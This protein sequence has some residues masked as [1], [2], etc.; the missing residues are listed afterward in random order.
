MLFGSKTD[1]LFFLAFRDHFWKI[2]I[3]VWKSFIICVQIQIYILTSEQV[4]V[5]FLP[6][7]IAGIQPTVEM[8]HH[9]CNLKITYLFFIIK[10]GFL[11]FQFSIFIKIRT[12][13]VWK[14]T[15]T[16]ADFGRVL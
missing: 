12:V 16:V 5:A 11:Q 9:F 10:C 7:E 6:I 1:L 8:I 14:D 4:K 15:K 3:I 13:F 2:I